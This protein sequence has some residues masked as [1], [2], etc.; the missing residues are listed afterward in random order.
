M[1]KKRIIPCLDIKG[2][3]VVKGTNFIELMDAGDPVELAVTYMQQGADELV[4]LDIS[5][6]NE[7]RK[8]LVSLVAQIAA[9]LKIPFTVGGG[10]TSLQDAA[11]LL[12]SGAD[13]IC[14]NSAALVRPALITEIASHFGSQCVVVAMDVLCDN[15]GWHV[16]SHG[17]TRNTEIG[18]LDW[19]LEAEAN[20]AGELLVTSIDNDGRKSGF[21]IDIISKIADTVNIPVI[22]SGGAGNLFH[23]KELFHKTAVTA[24]LAA[25]IFH[26]KEITIPQ[27]KSFLKN[28]TIP[29]R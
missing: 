13:K 23:F 12:K 22:A 3:R 29:V 25:S 18:A 14:I 20:G 8:T 7:E 21:A 24:A 6:T 16:H 11:A 26:Y 28:N 15:G 4:F 5:A 27:L 17:G 19:A 2:G 10:I 9:T 1:L